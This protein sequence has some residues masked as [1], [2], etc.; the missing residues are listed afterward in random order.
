[1]SQI[2]IIGGGLAGLAAATDL[3]LRGFEVVVF[4]KRKWPSHKVC[5]EYVSN[6]VLPYLNRLGAD[7]LS[8]G[9]VAIESFEFSSPNGRYRHTTLPLGG[10]SISRFALD[11]RMAQRAREAGATIHD[12]M[13][14]TGIEND[15]QR[16]TLIA[17]DGT[18][19]GFDVV[20]GAF[21]KRSK[22]DK[23]LD[24]PEFYH[25]TEYVGLKQYFRGAYPTHQVGLYHFGPGYLGISNVET[26]MLNVAVLV[27]SDALKGGKTPAQLLQEVIASQP[28]IHDHLAH[29]TPIL[30]NPLAIS[31]ISF[32]PRSAVHRGILMM[33]DAAG[34]IPPLAGNGM[35]MAIRAAQLASHEVTAYMKGQYSREEMEVR[36]ARGWN[37]EFQKRLQWGRR[38]QR[39]MEHEWACNIGLQLTRLVPGGLA[40]IVQQT[41]G[42]SHE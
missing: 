39:I 10:F 38:L 12:H 17:Q 34:V 41:H 29:A 33:G 21:G 32:L 8:W 42:T 26:G 35:A 15:A 22:M 24:R 14:I 31:N 28:R 13:E 3:S 6:E 16:M 36:Y 25:R 4:E 20:L 40:T 27:R 19:H 7:P 30:D 18:R 37:D 1:M 23:S 11:E 2:A 9:A 5:G